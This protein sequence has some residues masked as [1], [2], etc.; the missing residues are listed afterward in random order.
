MMIFA[1]PH[2]ALPQEGLK[3]KVIFK[4]CN[5]GINRIKAFMFRGGYVIENA[6]IDAARAAYIATLLEKGETSIEKY[7]GD[8][9]SIVELEIRPTLTNRLNKLKRQSPEAFYYWAKV[10]ELL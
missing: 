2:C 7:N 8:P 1:R 10:S 3:V 5:R 9:Q 4:C 6:I